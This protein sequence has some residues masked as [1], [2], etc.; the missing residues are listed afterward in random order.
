MSRIAK[1]LSII[2]LK[3]IIKKYYIQFYLEEEDI[4][5]ESEYYEDEMEEL[6]EEIEKN[7]FYKIV[8]MDC[9]K[10]D[11]NKLKNLFGAE[12]CCTKPNNSCYKNKVPCGFITLENGFSCLV[13]H[14]GG[15]GDVPV[16]FIVYYDGNKLRAYIPKSGNPWNWKT[17]ELFPY[18]GEVCDDNN[19]YSV[20][21]TFKQIPNQIVNPVLKKEFLE[22]YPTV[23][24][25]DFQ[26]NFEKYIVNWDEMKLDIMKR[27]QF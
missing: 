15:D 13:V 5:P 7:N 1:N 16:V 14:S 26:N 11:L 24:L 23:D 20:E 17:K 2:E 4:N 19:E 9:L 3:E 6:N 10:S 21:P 27:I 8:E 22:K 25:F 12:N 18:C